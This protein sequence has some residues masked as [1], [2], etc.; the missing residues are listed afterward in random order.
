MTNFPQNRT[1]PK[2]VIIVEDDDNLKNRIVDH[3]R[4][5][6]VDIFDVGTVTDFYQIITEYS[7]V[8]AIVDIGLPDQNGLHLIKYLRSHTPMR[9]V[10]L[11]TN[12]LLNEKV[13]AYDAGADY[14]LIKPVHM[15]ELSCLIWSQLKR[16]DAIPDNIENTLSHAAQNSFYPIA[17]SNISSHWKILQNGCILI[18]PQDNAI[19]L[20]MKEFQLMHILAVNQ[21]NPTPSVELLKSL[22]YQNNEY[23]KRSLESLIHRVRKKTSRSRSSPLLNAYGIGYNFT[24]P[25]TITS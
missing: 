21:S 25:I 2:R 15:N 14:C 8:L 5:E 19:K 10:A 11:T 7:F 12:S 17:V 16:I 22:D 1:L 23:G 20:T 24:A 6:N 9:I 13:A 18:D 4:S 3:L